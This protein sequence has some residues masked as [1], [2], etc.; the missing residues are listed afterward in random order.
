M[1]LNVKQIELPNTKNDGFEVD[2]SKIDTY[3][4]TILA[5]LKHIMED[6]NG[7]KTAYKTMA[8][9]KG[10]KGTW[11]DVANKCVNKAKTY[12]SNLSTTKTKL[13]NNL[14]DSLLAY[15]MAFIQSAQVVSN[16]ADKI[17]TNSE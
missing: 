1:A 5:D 10:T 16:A 7:I 9:D 2:T 6:V 17:K 8:D 12:N 15:I 4:D 3:K 14:T 11:K 13:Q